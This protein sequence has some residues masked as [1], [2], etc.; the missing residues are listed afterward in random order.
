M[1]DWQDKWYAGLDTEPS[2]RFC[3]VLWGGNTFASQSFE[4]P[5]MKGHLLSV[6]A[7]VDQ[8]GGDLLQKL[9]AILL[10]VLLP[11]GIKEQAGIN[12]AYDEKSYEQPE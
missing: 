9:L 2:A 1:K 3:D 7:G 6:P 11:C 5:G 4:T 12:A 10:V 8:A